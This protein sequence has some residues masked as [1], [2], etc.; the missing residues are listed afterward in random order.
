VTGDHGTVFHPHPERRHGHY[1]YDLY[2]A[3]LHVPL[4]VN[5]PGIAPRRCGDPVSTLDVAPTILDLVQQH[6]A[7]ASEGTSLMPELLRGLMAPQRVTFHEFYLGERDYRGQ[8]PLQMVSARAGPWN[9]V[10]DRERGVFELYDWTQDYYEERDL[11]EEAAMVPSVRALR[12]RLAA[13]LQKN[14][15]RP[16]GAAVLPPP[17]PGTR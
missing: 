5:G 9:L 15:V 1:G 3:T 14:H 13:F 12:T 17:P 7:L 6:E 8:D 4:V 2:T 11:F 16:R 10:L